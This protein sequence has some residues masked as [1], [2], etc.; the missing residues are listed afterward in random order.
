MEEEEI[1]AFLVKQ[2]K[3]WAKEEKDRKWSMQ[4]VEN[5]LAADKVFL[6]KIVIAKEYS[7]KWSQMYAAETKSHCECSWLSNLN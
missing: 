4:P 6:P 5:E 2:R 3:K 7:W 1:E